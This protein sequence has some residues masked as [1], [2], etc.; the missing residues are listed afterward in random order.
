MEHLS[1]YLYERELNACHGAEHLYQDGISRFFSVVLGS[2][3]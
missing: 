1:Q 3:L 2:A